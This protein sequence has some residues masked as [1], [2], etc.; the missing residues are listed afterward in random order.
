[1]LAWAAV[2]RRPGLGSASERTRA[3]HLNG[4]RT[5]APG[6]EPTLFTASSARHPYRR[7]MT[8][9]DPD[10]EA[11]PLGRPGADRLVSVGDIRVLFQLGRTEQPAGR[12]HA[13]EA[14]GMQGLRFHDLRHTGG[15]SATNS[16]A[17]LCGLAALMG[18]DFERP[19]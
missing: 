7:A 19:P 11:V 12:L 10:P 17:G 1:M 9:T 15:Q 8:L 14:L 3:R 2:M 16:G 18:H 6:H 4:R 5:G 13:V